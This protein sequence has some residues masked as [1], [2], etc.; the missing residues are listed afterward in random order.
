MCIFVKI[1]THSPEINYNFSL[2]LRVGVMRY[3]GDFEKRQKENFSA[4]H[5]INTR[6]RNEYNI[7]KVEKGS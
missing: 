2:R 1:I 4:E 5:Q 3:G 7:Y 6:I